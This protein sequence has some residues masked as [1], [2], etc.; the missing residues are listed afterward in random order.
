MDFISEKDEK[1][2]AYFF[3]KYSPGLHAAVKER[4]NKFFHDNSGKQ[5]PLVY[6]CPLC[7]H[8]KILADGTYIRSDD[9]FDIDHYPPK[10]AG[11]TNSVL[12]CKSCNSKAGH[13]YDYTIK[14]WLHSQA[15]LAGKSNSVISATVTLENVK[16]KYK[17]QLKMG[18]DKTWTIDDYEKYPLF[19]ARMKEMLSGKPVDSSWRFHEPD[20]KLVF[21][22]IVKAA[23]LYAFSVWGYDFAYTATGHRFRQII[24]GNEEHPLKN[25]GVFFQ[26]DGTYPPDGICMIIEPKNLQCFMVNLKIVEKETAFQCG[27]S[28]LIPG[29]YD[30]WDNIHQFKEVVE[31]DIFA[32]QAIKVPED[33]LSSK[34]VFPFTSFWE[35]RHNIQLAGDV[36]N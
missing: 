36:N 3:S 22:A 2:L 8:N 26:M 7:L 20:N 27:V 10:S 23:Y 31:K 15:F 29:G 6:L 32:H 12:V 34:N 33:Q 28:V 11:G 21:R 14:K 5:V 25:S 1:Q 24:L 4:L 18:N 30:E 35:N 13:D 19:S 9:E 17:G 16:G